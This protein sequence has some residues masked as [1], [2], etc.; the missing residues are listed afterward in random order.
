MGLAFSKSEYKEAL[1]KFSQQELGVLKKIFRD[2][3]TRHE[4]KTSIDKETFLK[5]FNVPGMLGERLFI[6]FDRKQSDEIDY[7]E[8]MRGLALCMKGSLDEKYQLIFEMYNLGNDEGLSKE[9]LMTMLYSVLRS[10]Q[11]ILDVS[12]QEEHQEVFLHVVNSKSPSVQKEEEEYDAYR[13]AKQIV[14]ETFSASHTNHHGKMTFDQF[15][16]WASQ[17]RLVLDSIFNSDALTYHTDR[18]RK[19]LKFVELR[20]TTHQVKSP[21]RLGRRLSSYYDTSHF[22]EDSIGDSTLLDC[23]QHRDLVY[24]SSSGKILMKGIIY[25]Q[26]KTFKNWKS[27]YFVIRDQFLYRYKTFEHFKNLKWSESRFLVGCF[28]DAFMDDEKQ[29]SGIFE[30]SYGIRVQLLNEELLLFTDSQESQQNWIKAFTI[31][32][33]FRN[34]QDHYI[35]AEM[36]GKGC[37]A[38]VYRAMCKKTGKSY[39][40]KAIRKEDLVPEEKECLRQEIACHK[41]T[42]HPNIVNLIDIF[43]TVDTLYLVLELMKGENLLSRIEHLGAHSEQETRVIMFQIVD[44]LAYLH[45]IGI[46]H[47]DLKPNNIMFKESQVDSSSSSSPV[48]ILDFGFSKLI[49]PAQ[50]LR[51][52][53]GTR[54]YFAPE[55][56]LGESYHKPVDMWCCGIILYRLL[57]GQFPFSGETVDDL[58]SNIIKA[59]YECS[60]QSWTCLS[61][62]SRDLIRGLLRRDPSLRLTAHETLIH[63]FFSNHL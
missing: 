21:R 45:D 10:A 37:Y 38:T 19:D 23:P 51:G 4:P 40:I 1:E 12:I 60:D 16:L 6:V 36:I 46:V 8:F 62:N 14:D 50:G 17:N 48:K 58:F 25:K 24:N 7:E 3:A 39:A 32:A 26:G 35:L 15:K 31:A 5:Y 43:D 33:E 13:C 20:E 61:S 9:E 22:E 2:L 47:R 29:K 44:A 11:R 30:K 34:M 49:L 27:R 54:K 55:M 59:R 63:P 41:L 53:A 18:F 56:V 42:S 57:T 52:V 28:V